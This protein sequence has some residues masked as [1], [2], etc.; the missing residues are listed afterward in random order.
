MARSSVVDVQ[1][2]GYGIQILVTS[3]ASAAVFVSVTGNGNT[4]HSYNT[5]TVSSK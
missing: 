1:L 3:D 2:I 5:V 4:R